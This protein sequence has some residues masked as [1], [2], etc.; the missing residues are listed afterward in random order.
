MPGSDYCNLPKITQFVSGSAR[1]RREAVIEP[2]AQA[3]TASLSVVPASLPP[4]PDFL[5]LTRR[6][7]MK[8]ECKT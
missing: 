5:L 1:I 6:W 4:P 8:Q 2:R 3:R 7:Q